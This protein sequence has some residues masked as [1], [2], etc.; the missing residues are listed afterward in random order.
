[1]EVLEELQGIDDVMFRAVSFIERFFHEEKNRSRPIKL[2]QPQKDAIDSIQFGFPLSQYDFDEVEKIPRGVVMIWPRQ[3]GKTLGCAY[4]ASSLLV[5]K[6]GCAIGIIAA[7][8]KQSKKLFNKIK[9]ILK[10]S[11]F[12]DYVIPKSVRVDYLELTNG[13]YVECWPCTDG[14]EGSTYDLLFVDEAHL[15][16]EKIIFQSAMP[17]VTHGERWIMLSTPKGPKGKFI[18]YYYKGLETRDII[19][20]ACGER[21]PQAAFNVDRFPNG[22]MPI[23]DMHKCP[24][25]GAFDYKYGVGLFATPYVDAWNDG[26]RPKWYVKQLLDEAGW[27]PTARQEYLGEIISDASMVFLGEWLKACTNKKLK[28]IF[29]A[30]R[31]IDYVLGVDYGRK[32]DASCFYITHLDKKSGRIILDFGMSVA[33][34]YDEHKT[35][36]YIRDKLLKVIQVFNPT[37]IVPDAT[38]LGDPL[39]EQLQEDLENLRRSNGIPVR[40]QIFDNR[41]NQKGFIISRITKPE[42]IGNLIKTFAQNRIEIPPASEPEIGNLREELLRFECD[43]LPGTDYIKYGTQSFHDD[44][45]IALALS[46]WGHRRRPTYL[47]KLKIRGVKLSYG[48]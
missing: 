35:Y 33:G 47:D 20:K 37:W 44:R 7:T 27:S 40:T 4:A 3:T 31:D 26:L 19:C 29:R 13:S 34:E 23:E 16:D 18:E 36:R 1:V 41:Q 14:I 28:N 32:H 5:I 2:T 25:C 12:W 8:E 22:K 15:M 30:R 42:L 48:F 45:V 6:P 9:K 24:M 39:V 10:H 17:T 21:F 38:G 46:C 11:I 43:E